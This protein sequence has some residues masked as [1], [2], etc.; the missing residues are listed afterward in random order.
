MGLKTKRLGALRLVVS[1]I[2]H[3]TMAKEFEHSL[4]NVG[5]VRPKSMSCGREIQHVELLVR[6]DQSINKPQGVGRVDVI[7]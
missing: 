1:I 2:S 6:F 4:R 7:V 3:K 5:L